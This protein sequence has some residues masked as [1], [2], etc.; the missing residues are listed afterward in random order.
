MF[1]F[2]RVHAELAAHADRGPAQVL[3]ALTT[4]LAAHGGVQ[5]D[6]VTLLAL[7]YVGE[8]DAAHVS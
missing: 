5:D 3:E 1:G 8:L 2:D 7:K 6:D 4:R